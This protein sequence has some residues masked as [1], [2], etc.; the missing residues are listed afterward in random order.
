[1]TLSLLYLASAAILVWRSVSDLASG[2]SQRNA[3][4]FL[5]LVFHFVVLLGW[6]LG[7]SGVWM[8]YVAAAVGAIHAWAWPI[9]RGVLVPLRRWRLA[10]HV[11]SLSRI[12]WP[13][14]GGGA[15][16]GAWALLR[17]GGHHP[18]AIA[19]LEARLRE[20]T[21][22]GADI[23]AAGLLAAARGES[24]AARQLLESLELLDPR[25][26]RQAHRVARDYLIA[27]AAEAGDW[28]RV[29]QL[30]AAG[31]PISRLSRFVAAA[32]ARIDGSPEA[33]GDRRLRA[34]WLLAP[35]RRRTLALLRRALA[36]RFAA[37]R[38][39][40]APLSIQL[41]DGDPVAR[42]LDAHLQL[43]CRAGLIE[44]DD[45]A[46]LGSLWDRAIDSGAIAA[47]AR[48]RAADLGSAGAD[49]AA[50]DFTAQIESE[51]AAMIRG[52]GV[53]LEL[54]PG[55]SPTLSRAVTAVRESLLGDVELAF[56]ALEERTEATRTLPG[57]D[58]W[59]EILALRRLHAQAARLGGLPLRRL[60]FPPIHGP[61]CNFA[62]WLWNDRDELLIAEMI[63]RWL[64]GEATI[65]GDG[66]AI[67]LQRR[68]VETAAG[69]R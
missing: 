15:V 39:W 36:V 19:F 56:A 4:L 11:G 2:E 28:R 32:A 10:Y 55:A 31:F 40:P 24:D 64:L 41:A 66:E 62:A 51:I 14:G 13:G 26:D 22:R 44:I 57:I 37:A 30:A 34:L 52:A 68:N 33:P 20:G 29:Q 16:A 69:A 18:D 42:A 23:V 59:R 35:R 49:R 63:F 27:E 65:V 8:G 12:V 53:C 48:R 54:L 43:L 7:Q 1:M 9:A 61:A 46:L 50:A 17:R 25:R 5:A 38:P 60:A 21:L 67:E 3:G 45:L 58:E 47:T 6:Q